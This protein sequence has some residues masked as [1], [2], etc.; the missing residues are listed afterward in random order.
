MNEA[1]Q[2]T[3]ARFVDVALGYDWS[4]VTALGESDL[5]AFYWV[6]NHAGFE[7]EDFVTA[8]LHGKA[9]DREGGEC[10]IVN[11]VCPVTVRVKGDALGRDCLPT[12][13]LNDLLKRVRDASPEEDRV[14]IVVQEMERSVPLYPIQLTKEGDHLCEVRR[15]RMHGDYPYLVDH[16]RD[17]DRL[18]PVLGLHEWCGGQIERHRTSE[19]Y[20]ALFC[21][22]C[23]L[24]HTLPIT[25]GT[26]RDLRKEYDRRLRLE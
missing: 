17:N 2:R 11:D 16:A 13:W 24:R 8:P 20:T 7:V 6:L 18:G 5:A 9:S 26:Y 4:K 15:V 21:R 1:L 19:H 10:Y 14:A 22:A 23:L 12:G 25:I 3:A